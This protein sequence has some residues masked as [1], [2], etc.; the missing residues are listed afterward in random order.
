MTLGTGLVHKL[1][2][3]VGRYNHVDCY[4]HQN[5]ME[6]IIDQLFRKVIFT[7]SHIN[8]TQ[9]DIQNVRVVIIFPQFSTQKQ[10][11]VI[12]PRNFEGNVSCCLVKDKI[13]LSLHNLTQVFDHF[14][15]LF[16]FK[17]TFKSFH[18][19]PCTFWSCR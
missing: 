17:I 8:K 3:R 12:L 18:L 7:V 4:Q 13:R 11:F 16:L 9:G 10:H 15:Y 6:T 14:P 2:V 1:C 5:K 19:R